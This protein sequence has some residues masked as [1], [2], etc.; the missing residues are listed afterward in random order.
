MKWFKRVIKLIVIV[1][2]ILAVAD[3]ALVF[4]IAHYRRNIPKTDAVVVLGAAIYTPA[5][6]NRTL[7]G[8]KLYQDGK[9]EQMVLSGGRIA[10]ADISEAQ[11]MEKVLKANVNPAPKY[12]LEEQSHTTYENIHNSRQKLDGKLSI[13]IVS[14]EFHLARAVLIAKREGFANVYWSAPQ[15]T[16]YSPNEL[17]FYYARELLAMFS[18]LPKF[19]SG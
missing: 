13:I 17:R 16:Y 14:D 5:L 11:Y 19:I 4:G 6:Y 7:E 18:Y 1:F 10:S 15:P 8:L 2:V 3:I 9:A 12:I